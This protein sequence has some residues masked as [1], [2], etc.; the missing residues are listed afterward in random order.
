MNYSPPIGFLLVE[1]NC[2]L[3]KKQSWMFL[4]IFCGVRMMRRQAASRGIDV[5]PGHE[6]KMAYL[7]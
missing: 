5:M 1:R 2:Y 7:S 6:Q 4:S 3:E